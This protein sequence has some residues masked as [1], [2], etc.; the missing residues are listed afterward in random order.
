MDKFKAAWWLP[1]GHSQ[2]LWRKF[3]YRTIIPRQRERIELSDGDF[4]DIDWAMKP[5]A[6]DKTPITVILHGLCGCSSS[7]YVIALQEL[8]KAQ[9][10][11]SVAM[12]FRGCSGVINRLA[13]AYHSGASED[14]QEVFTWLRDEFPNT[15][16]NFVGYSLGANVLLK[17]LG[18][19]QVDE[20]VSAAVAVSPPF[21]LADCSK[22]M[23][24][25]RGLIYGSYF[26]K[27][28]SADLR[29]KKSHFEATGTESQRQILDSL[30]AL[31]SSHSLWDFDD[32]VTAPLH[33]F[34]SAQ[35][36]Y[37]RCSAAEYL[38]TN[39]TST[40]IIHSSNDPIIPHAV[41]P[42]K[43]TLPSNIELEL[44]NKGGHVGFISGLTN[45]WLERRIVA[46]ISS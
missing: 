12:N 16:F 4:I 27:Q 2:T 17:W 36:Y 45:N 39:E 43:N 15:L 20:Q 29:R 41:V 32:L 14:L 19:N 24:T 44:Y 13:R 9:C 1:E 23:L 11:P 18:E 10:L 6:E 34:A 33:G 26:F 3:S 40:L 22:A 31:H 5:S 35:D 25:G 8:L 38:A 28:L 42:A 21:R 7:P 46:Q 37:D 30:P